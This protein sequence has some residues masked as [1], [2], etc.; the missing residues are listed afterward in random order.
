LS[1]RILN[2]NGHT[3]NIKG[4]ADERSLV[5]DTGRGNGPYAIV[6]FS[7]DPG[8]RLAGAEQSCSQRGVEE[9]DS[10]KVA[11]GVSERSVHNND[12]HWKERVMHTYIGMAIDF[13]ISKSRTEIMD[14]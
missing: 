4:A 7:F 6:L 12:W 13:G 2:P 3:G 1:D 9:S 8:I 14:G 10:P 5:Y 11:V